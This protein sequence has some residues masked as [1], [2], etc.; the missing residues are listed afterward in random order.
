MESALLYVH[1][2]ASLHTGTGQALDAI[3][4]PIARERSTG[5]PIA[6][7]SGIKGVLRDEARSRK[8][9]D[10]ELLWGVFGPDTD[11]ATEHAGAVTFLDAR[12][13]LFPVVC[14]SHL[15]AWVTSPYLLRRYLRDR[16]DAGLALTEED[17]AVLDLEP[18][19]D[20]ALVSD[21]RL[22][23]ANRESRVFLDDADLLA[24]TSEPLAGFSRRLSERLLA[25]EWVSTLQERLVLVSDREV[26]H[27]TANATEVVARVKIGEQNKTVESFWYEEALPPETILYAMV[28]SVD[29]RR[30][31]DG[32]KAK[33]HLEKLAEFDSVQL[34]G[35][36]S[37]GRGLCHLMWEI[38][39]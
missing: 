17:R 31:S 6:P 35:K 25:P 26:K 33:V 23:V 9:W 5:L 10:L 12:L 19:P 11:N 2:M 18:G 28:L 27:F 4:L 14:V 16:Q 24:E 38:R 1:A 20:H 8:E 15:F 34:G 22:L 39:S 29:S 32:I 7:G 13:L 21:G 30:K 37:V 36:A 3:D